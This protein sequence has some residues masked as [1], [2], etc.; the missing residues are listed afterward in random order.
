VSTKS[1]SQPPPVYVIE[2]IPVGG[3]NEVSPAEIKAE[4]IPTPAHLRI[5][6]ELG[7]GGMGRIHPATDRNL[8]R[9]LALKR[10][11]KELAREPFYRDGFVAEA[12]MTGQLEHP[13][14]V[15][16]HELA[17]DPSGVPYFT[18]KLVQG[19]S[20]EHWLREPSRTLGST[21]RIE[22]GLEVFVK[23]CDAMAYAHHRGVIHRDLKPEN[24][25]V[26]GFGQVYLMDWGLAR[27]TRTKPAS[28]KMAQ[29]EAPGPVGTPGYMAPEQARGNPAEMDERSDVFGLGAVLYQIVTGKTPFGDNPDPEVTMKLSRAGAVVPIEQAAAAIGV[30][31]RLRDIVA[32]ATAP[33]PA[34]RYPSVVELQRD[35]VSFLR[36]GL[37][38]PRK[39]FQPGALI[40]REGDIGDAAYMI[41]SGRCRAYRTVGDSQETLVVMQGGDVFGEMALLLDEP[42]AASVEAVDRVTVLVL[43]KSTMT[44]GLGI[45]GWTGALVRALAQ[46]FRDLE[47]KVRSS[48]MRRPSQGPP[49]AP[50]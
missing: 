40:I 47:Q 13:N 30:S 21:E 35:V 8:L 39:L 16:V 4:G 29:M 25:M 45:G 15:P 10:L 36:G 6:K 28:G 17:I 41:V 18:M 24:I 20:F 11:D 2:S 19:V 38:L 1:P 44:E 31:K 34:D 42:R 22:E 33:K 5:F 12:Q 32:R 14:I 50:P 37:H 49:Q 9:H 46:R 43:D 27:L 23:V 7:R 3:A 48:G 26:A